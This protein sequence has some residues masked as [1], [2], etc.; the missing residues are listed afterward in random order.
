MNL[1]LLAVINHTAHHLECE[2]KGEG[3]VLGNGCYHGSRCDCNDGVEVLC[4][5]TYEELGRVQGVVICACCGELSAEAVDEH[6]TPYCKRCGDEFE[7]Q[8]LSELDRLATEAMDRFFAGG[9]GGFVW[10]D[11][12][13]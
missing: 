9:P 1:T 13:S 3:V 4:S 12:E 2:C 7:A 8:E 11:E 5:C 6:G 10:E